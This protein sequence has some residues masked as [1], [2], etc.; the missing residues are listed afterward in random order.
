MS[1]F[2]IELNWIRSMFTELIHLITNSPWEEILKYF[3][4]YVKDVFP[5]IF[6]Q[7]Q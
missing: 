5:Q 6:N 2:D 7:A 3:I 1:S 4:L